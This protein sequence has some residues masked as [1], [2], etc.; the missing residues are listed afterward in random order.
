M[1]VGLSPTASLCFCV[2]HCALV[3]VDTRGLDPTAAQRRRKDLPPCRPHC[4]KRKNKASKSLAWSSC[5][6]VRQFFLL[7]QA[8]QR[9]SSFHR[10]HYVR[11]GT[12]TES[13]STPPESLSDRRDV[14][15][16]REQV[17][18]VQSCG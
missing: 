1:G 5:G 16:L 9:V 17:L 13:T 3:T 6:A 7:S 2:A 18:R 11:G 4:G 14:E 15:Q 8:V 10:G 12:A